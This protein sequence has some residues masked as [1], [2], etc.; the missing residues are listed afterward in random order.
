M[1][2]GIIGA[3]LMG[4]THARILA[5]SV[6]GAEVVAIADPDHEAAERI[7]G[8]HVIHHD[9]F[10]L[11]EAASVDAVIVASP[12]FTHEPYV[13]ACLEAGKAVLCEKPLAG[14]AATALRIVE[15]ENGRA[16]IT[17]GF[18]RRFD[19]GYVDLKA[20]LDAG[21][22][23]APLLV[24]CAHRN[25][26]VHE[27]FDSAMIITDSAVHEVDVTRWL[28]GE[29]IVRVRVLTPRPS[30]RAREGLRDPQLIIFETAGGR[31]VDVEAFVSA[32][33]GYDIR[34][35]VVGEDGT[36]ELLAPSTVAAARRRR[37]RSGPAGLPGA[38]RGRLPPRAAELGRGRARRQRLRR[39]R[40]RRGL[41]GR[42]RLAGV[43]RAGRRAPQRGVVGPS[44][45]DRLDDLDR[46]PDRP[47]E[48]L[49]AAASRDSAATAR[50][51]AATTPSGSRSCPDAASAATLRGV[52]PRTRALRRRAAVFARAC[53]C[54]T[55]RAPAPAA[56]HA[57][58]SRGRRTPTTARTSRAARAA[59]ATAAAP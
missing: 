18:M 21:A 53:S 48:P 22:I 8:G 12:V 26:S 50:T 13:L 41:R 11:I 24:H 33:Y 57:T 20:R 36:L 30:S 54:K 19:P 49:R 25:P 43:R 51:P 34:C 4:S 3:G 38:L 42:G 56:P 44:L 59:P 37:V 15:A 5:E 52:I 1:N 39:L 45:G 6:P 28:L 7:A 9:A 58:R 55:D 14:D 35:E 16:L 47:R 40:G 29:E 46:Q 23:G 10:E 32:G 17:V 27:F 2:V 31:L